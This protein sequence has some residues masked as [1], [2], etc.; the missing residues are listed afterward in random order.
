MASL[1]SKV[2]IVTGGARGIGRAIASRLSDA[3]AI[4]VIGDLNEPADASSVDFAPLNVT[5]EASIQSFLDRVVT[6]H[7]GLDIVVNNAGIMFEKSIDEQS[8]EDWDLMMGVN[9]KG[10]F[11]VTKHAAP[12]LR[13]RGGGAVVN[14]FLIFLDLQVY[15]GSLR[16][17]SR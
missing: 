13:T 14:R 16:S 3:G 7:G 4:V 8:A 6:N 12:H 17:K 11:L 9:L 15:R 2:A 10:P 5:D 1:H